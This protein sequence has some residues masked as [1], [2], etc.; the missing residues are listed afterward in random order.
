MM[1]SFHDEEHKSKKLKYEENLEIR[2]EEIIGDSINE[3]D[4]YIKADQIYYFD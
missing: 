4:G 1:C 2:A 3:K